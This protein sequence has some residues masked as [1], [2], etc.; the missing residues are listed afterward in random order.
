MAG[1]TGFDVPGFVP[2]IAGKHFTCLYDG[3]NW[4]LQR[5]PAAVLLVKGMVCQDRL[6]PRRGGL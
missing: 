5:D 2:K 6:K 3:S 1:Y 4:L